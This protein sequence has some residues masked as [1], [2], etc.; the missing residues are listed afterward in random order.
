MSLSVNCESSSDILKGAA[1]VDTDAQA[2]GEAGPG[3]TEFVLF[4]VKGGAESDG[5]GGIKL[6]NSAG[7]LI[8][9]VSGTNNAGDTTSLKLFGGAG[10]TAIRAGGTK[11]MEVWD[12]KDSDFEGGRVELKGS[13]SVKSSTFKVTH[14]T[15]LDMM[16]KNLLG[17]G[18]ATTVNPMSTPPRGG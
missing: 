18:S 15:G 11:K 12:I 1:S 17:A 2:N 4:E 3:A 9:E 16:T 14:G 10:A 7:T 5:H 13:G 6:Y 8:T